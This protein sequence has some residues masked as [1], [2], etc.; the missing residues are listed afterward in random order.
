VAM[1]K[2]K[3]STPE[4]QVH[5]TFGH[6]CTDSS[7]IKTVLVFIV[8]HML[9]LWLPVALLV[10][11]LLLLAFPNNIAKG[12]GVALIILYVST[13]D[14]SHKRAPAS[15][16][17]PWFVNLPVVRY[18]LEWL[19]MKI[20]RTAVLDKDQLYV[21]AAHPHGTLAFNRGAVGFST[22]TLWDAAFPGVKFRVLTA[23]AAFFVPF[24]REMW[25]WSYCVDASKPTA[26][27]VLE[28]EK[29]SVFVYPGGEKEQLET[30]YGEHRVILNSRKGFVKLA[31][32]HGAHLVP[33]YAFG[34]T[35]LYYHSQHLIGFRKWLTNKF[36]VA[37]PFLWGQYG[38]LPFRTPITLVF[39][40]PIIVER[41][42]AP[43]HD[44]INIVHEKY[45]S[46]LV[47]L[48][49]DHKDSLGYGDKNLI[50]L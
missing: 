44:D 23:T 16:P 8:F 32:E 45:V 6:E 37:I 13:F 38:L 1:T 27:R 35:N 36:G 34:E 42:H 30:V 7:T 46:A 3:T 22:H 40:K 4:K 17:W 19:P 21:F 28:V 18:V 14:G 50:V 48:F 15:K 11:P 12:I 41:K 29:S 31:I 10:C 26:V 9:Y 24:I 20:R 47:Q 33:V 49:D 43:S 25:L 2:K 5:E 39:G